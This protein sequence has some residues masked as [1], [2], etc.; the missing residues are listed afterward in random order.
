MVIEVG[1]VVCY[2]YG[3]VEYWEIGM[4]DVLTFYSICM[5]EMSILGKSRYLGRQDLRRVYSVTSE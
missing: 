2:C 4:E 5:H 1:E 3:S